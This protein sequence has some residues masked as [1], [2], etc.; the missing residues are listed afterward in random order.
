M[1]TL[2]LKGEKI[3]SQMDIDEPEGD[4]LDEEEIKEEGTGEEG[5]G[6]EEEEDEDLV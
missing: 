6:T 4:D 3:T 1:T 5:V 2:E